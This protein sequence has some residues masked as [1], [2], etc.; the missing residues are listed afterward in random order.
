MRTITDDRGD[1]RIEIRIFDHQ[2]DV[3]KSYP[4]NSNASSAT[5]NLTREDISVLRTALNEW[6]ATFK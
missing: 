5:I 6:A 1:E 2:I 4:T 3:E